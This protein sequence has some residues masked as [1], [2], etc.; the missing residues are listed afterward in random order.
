MSKI[1]LPS[2]I[3]L[4]FLTVC[5]NAYSHGIIESPASRQ[6][7]CGVLTK[8]EQIYD[9]KLYEEKCRPIM[10]KPDGS[11]DDSLYNFM[12]VL[13]HSK[14]HAEG[15]PAHVCGFNSETWGNGKTPWDT[16]MDWPTV[17]IQ[18]GRQPFV[19]NISW[20]NHFG[21]TEEFVYWITK[22]EFKFD[23]N[24]ELSWNDFEVQPFCKLK[25]DDNNPAA[26][27]DIKPDKSKNIFTTYCNVPNRQNRA[28]IYA[29]WGRN[30]WTYERFHACM[31]VV[32]DSPPAYTIKSVIQAV[33]S[34]IKGKKL[35]PWMARSLSAKI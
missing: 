21:D 33:S 34:P 12:A 10:T 22:P 30:E 5:Q 13:T 32:F 3:S 20:G 23:P 24:K 9:S 2:F 19:W 17:G 4:M 35:L 28:V 7:F 18:G 6:Q 26:N 11:M 31:D 16:A 29:E 25:Y 14:G 1:L 15:S 8:P 27:P